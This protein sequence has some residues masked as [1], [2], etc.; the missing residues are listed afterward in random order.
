[1][2]EPVVVFNKRGNELLFTLSGV[3]VSIAN[4]IRRTIISD[5]PCVVFETYPYEKNK[6]VI[7]S[8][9]TKLNNEIIKQRL[10]C[11]P[12]HI[13]D[14]T[15]PLE[16][17]KLIVKKKNDSDTIQYITTEDFKIYDIKNEKFISDAE[18]DKIFPAD[19]ITKRYIDIA[20]L[21]PQL[22]SEIRGEELD[23]E[24]TFSISSAK[25]NGMFNIVSTCAYGNTVDTDKGTVALAKYLKQAKADGLN[26]EEIQIAEKNWN[27]LDAQRHYVADSYDFEIE[28]V[29]VF[30]NV[31]IAKASCQ[32]IIKQ[33][34]QLREI[35]EKG[36][37]EIK[38]SSTTMENSYDIK[39]M[40]HDYTIGKLL[41]FMLY[42]QYFVN[43]KTMSFCGFRKNHP[44]DSFS[45]IRVAYNESTEK[46]SVINNVVYAIDLSIE[47]Y[48]KILRQF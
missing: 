27:I 33:L 7:H 13:T 45:I 44:H 40:N 41:E 38:D 10:S 15:L 47:I 46:L 11:V 4:A 39:L 17:Y 1:M 31:E 19:S 16:N 42:D 9:T 21:R 23:F 22:S 48:N 6:C 26:K 12:I 3:N 18:N 5:I 29:G 28:S 2:T 8:N 32:V 34:Q 37:V 43:K 20:K 14:L 30:D 25:Q 24:C 35:F 36:N